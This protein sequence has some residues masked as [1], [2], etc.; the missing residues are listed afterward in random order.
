M[1]F[2]GDGGVILKRSGFSGQC[3]L[4][5]TKGLDVIVMSVGPGLRFNKDLGVTN[6]G[7]PLCIHTK[8]SALA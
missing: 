6:L 8:H 3:P 1:F 5:C 7:S 4:G 2:V